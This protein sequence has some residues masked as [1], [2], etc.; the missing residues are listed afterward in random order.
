MNAEERARL[1]RE[2]EVSGNC[3]HP[4]RLSG[5]MVNIATGEVNS[6]ALRVACKDRRQV[7][8][9]ACSDVYQTDAW[10]LV[11]A[12]LN[13]GKGVSEEVGRHPRLFVTL[14]AP[15]FGAVHTI[16]AHGHCVGARIQRPR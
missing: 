13:G 7:V 10:I 4:I 2:V 6:G 3:S 8:C 9:P 11:A 14:T 16:T 5:E 1:L 15:S 12:G